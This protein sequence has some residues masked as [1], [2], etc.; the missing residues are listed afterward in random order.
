MSQRKVFAKP[1]FKAQR[2]PHEQAAA[3]TILKP[4]A[5]GIDVHSDMHMVC[6]PAESVMPAAS[7]DAGG[8]FLR[9]R[10][11]SSWLGK[12]RLV[13][14][15]FGAAATFGRLW[16]VMERRGGLASTPSASPVPPAGIVLASRSSASENL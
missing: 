11:R 13:H 12:H 9:R 8:C 3:M 7:S 15:G 16:A 4:K 14:Q 10:S 5:A 6:V 2:P 1:K